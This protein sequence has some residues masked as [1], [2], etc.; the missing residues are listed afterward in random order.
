MR[1]RDALLSLKRQALNG[2]YD[3]NVPKEP[4]DYK[5]KYLSEQIPDYLHWQQL[6]LTSV[7]L[8]FECLDRIFFGL[9]TPATF[10]MQILQNLFTQNCSHNAEECNLLQ[11]CLHRGAHCP[12]KNIF[13]DNPQPS[14][15]LLPQPF[16]FREFGRKSVYMAGERIGIFIFL[17]AGA[18]LNVDGQRN[19]RMFLKAAHQLEETGVGETVQMDPG[20]VRLMVANVPKKNLVYSNIEAQISDIEDEEPVDPAEKAKMPH[21]RA[22]KGNLYNSKDGWIDRD[23]IGT[24]LFFDISS[25]G[26]ASSLQCVTLEFINPMQLKRDGEILWN[27]T[28]VDIIEFLMKRLNRLFDLVPLPSEH[29]ID[30]AKYLHLARQAQSINDFHIYKCD[31]FDGAF[32]GIYGK[33]MVMGDMEPFKPMLEMAGYMNLGENCEMG[34]GQF[35]VQ[36][37]FPDPSRYYTVY[38]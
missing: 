3:E 19:L 18:G 26:K 37:T 15:G 22:I 34:M 6:A 27:P 11:Y 8:E 5:E 25:F 7:R 16:I 9:S 17:M 30:E 14:F 24:S 36:S 32:D 20:P 31:I 38:Y 4:P 13:C 10:G 33:M 1:H 29:K 21:E 12:I 2:R 35:Y 23:T 28:F